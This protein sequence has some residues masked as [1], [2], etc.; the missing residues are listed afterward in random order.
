LAD[1]YTYEIIFVYFVSRF[2]YRPLLRAVSTAEKT[3]TERT[4]RDFAFLTNHG[5]TLLLIAR[6]QRIRTREIAAR[7]NITER[8]TQSIVAD[9][10]R[11]GYIDRTR[12]GRRNLYTVRTDAPLGLPVQR[13]IDIGSLIGLLPDQDEPTDDT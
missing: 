11:A 4:P 2:W 1:H 9:L 10:A 5:K 8:A 3:E 13:D 6:N 12:I 7:L